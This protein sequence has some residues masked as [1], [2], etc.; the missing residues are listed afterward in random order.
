MHSLCAST[1]RPFARRWQRA[2]CSLLLMSRHFDR[3]TISVLLRHAREGF[4][5]AYYSAWFTSA[6]GERRGARHEHM[7]AQ[8]TRE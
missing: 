5:N 7:S 8:F 4:L 6:A 2:G 1:T 3:R